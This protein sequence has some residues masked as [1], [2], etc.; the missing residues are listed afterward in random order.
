VNSTR[1]FLKHGKRHALILP[2]NSKERK[3]IGTE[4]IYS[5]Q[6]KKLGFEQDVIYINFQKK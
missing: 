4:E 3:S 2:N 5:F 1:I 6:K